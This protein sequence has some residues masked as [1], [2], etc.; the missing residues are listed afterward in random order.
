ME[1]VYYILSFGATRCIGIVRTMAIFEHICED[2]CD[3]MFR[4][5]EDNTYI[6]VVLFGQVFITY[7]GDIVVL[8]RL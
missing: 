4:Y 5:C 7:E 8:L 2:L 3:E 1:R 6:I